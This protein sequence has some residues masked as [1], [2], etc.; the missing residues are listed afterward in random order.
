MF[1]DTGI[2]YEGAILARQESVCS[3]CSDCPYAGID[4][5]KSQCMEIEEIYPSWYEGGIKPCI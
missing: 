1:Y 3:D 4:T 2:D 5:C